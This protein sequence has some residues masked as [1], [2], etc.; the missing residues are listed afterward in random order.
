M[1]AA[2]SEE[3]ALELLVSLHRFLRTLRKARPDPRLQPTQLVVLALLAQYGPL[4]IGVIA[5]RIPCSQPTV[6][7]AVA[8]L[9][10]AGLVRREPDPADG[11]AIR[12]VI[13]ESSSG[14]MST[15]AHS[16]AGALAERLG[17]L[18]P[19]DAQ[20]VLEAGRLLRRLTDPD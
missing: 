10:S 19:Q 17:T 3:A 20:K 9:E 1:T 12:V 18:S 16:Q 8:S 11:R 4:R 6:T 5:D 15:V 13:T 2:V 7:A 14:T